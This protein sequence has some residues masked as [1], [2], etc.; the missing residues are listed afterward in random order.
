MTAGATHG[1]PITPA[2]RRHLPRPL[3]RLGPGLVAGASDSGQGGRTDRRV[4]VV[5]ITRDRADQLA[6]SLSRLVA[7]QERPHVIVVDNASRDDT[8]AMVRRSFPEV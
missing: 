1:A 8:V 4:T 7:L 6:R 5:V 2:A 3:R